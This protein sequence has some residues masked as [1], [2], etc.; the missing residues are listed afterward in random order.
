MFLPCRSYMTYKYMYVIRGDGFQ[1]VNLTISLNA[2]HGFH[3]L[4]VFL[5]HEIKKILALSL[6]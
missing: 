6:D 1:H 5:E 4:F 2:F 3:L